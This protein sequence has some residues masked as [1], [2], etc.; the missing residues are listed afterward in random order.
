[1]RSV[2][3]W[4]NVVSPTLIAKQGSALFVSTPRGFTWFYDLFMLGVGGTDPE[5]VSFT[6][7]TSDNPYIMAH[8]IESARRRLPLKMF[9][10]EYLARFITDAGEVFRNVMA[11]A[12]AIEQP[13][14]IPGHRYFMSVDLA[15]QEDFSCYNIIDGTMRAQ[16]YVE[17]DQSPDYKIQVG[18]I[19]ALYAIWRPEILVVESNAMGQSVIDMIT[20]YGIPVHSLY[21]TNPL[22]QQLVQDAVFAFDTKSV[23]IL[24]IP[25]QIQEFQSYAMRVSRETGLIRYGAPGRRNDDYVSSFII[26]WHE[27]INQ[28]AVEAGY[29]RIWQ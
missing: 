24:N 4:E 18:R 21:M 28:G 8:E 11:C 17:R 14:P 1:M 25:D 26:G 6:L 19:A 12:T 27:T 3:A 22:K 16:A 9:E 5:W 29:M 13:G 2:Y 7:P 10:Q 20:G 15:K 23:Q